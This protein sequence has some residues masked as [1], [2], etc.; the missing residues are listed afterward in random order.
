M[1]GSIGSWWYAGQA[2]VVLDKASEFVRVEALVP[3][4][5]HGV[6]QK[7]QKC[8]GCCRLSALTGE[9]KKRHDVSA[10]INVREEL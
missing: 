5:D 2:A 10:F 3:D 9:E 4:G 7:Q 1:A 6:G 8:F